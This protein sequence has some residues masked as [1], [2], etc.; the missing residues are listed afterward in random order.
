MG[1][2]GGGGREGKRR[3]NIAAINILE[4]V[5]TYKVQAST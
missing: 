2:G 1:G 5:D 4:E 3:E